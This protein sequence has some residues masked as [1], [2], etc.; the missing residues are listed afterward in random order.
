MPSGRK[1][2]WTSQCNVARSA[3]SQRHPSRL[4]ADF[5]FVCPECQFLALD[6][7]GL[8][9]HIAASTFC[10]ASAPTKDGWAQLMGNGNGNSLNNRGDGNSSSDD[11]EQAISDGVPR[12]REISA[13]I[14]WDTTASNSDSD[15]DQEP[16]E[17]P[18]AATTNIHEQYELEE[19]DEHDEFPATVDDQVHVFLADLCRRI[20]APLYAYDEILQWAQEAKLSGY[21]FPTTAPTYKT[22]LSSLK[23]RLGLDHLQHGTAA[24]QKCGGGT[25]EF[26]VFEFESMFCDLIDDVRVSK[27]LLINFDDP[28]KTPEYNNQFLD[29]VHSGSW[30][31]RTSD[32]LLED[33]NDVLCGIIFFFDRTHVA[34]KD[35]LSL[36]P[37]MFTLS[38]IPRSV[39][40][41][42]FA[43]RPLGYYPKLPSSLKKGNNMDTFTDS[44]TRCYPAWWVSKGKVALRV[45]LWPRMVR[46][47]YFALRSP[48]AMS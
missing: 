15:S 2:Y 21:T 28:T 20:Q 22:L 29:E 23:K 40:N 12:A 5:V 19:V 24:I 42:P 4:Q 13:P 37:L 1:C 31:R 3:P 38:I 25:L 8:L 47:R 46:P 6:A 26:P 11:E 36:C 44:S 17:A 14:N 16:T 34:N 39:R 27:H 43:W 9:Q 33:E 41:Q 10:S 30:H 32:L 45:L 7:S 18:L 48:C 35:K